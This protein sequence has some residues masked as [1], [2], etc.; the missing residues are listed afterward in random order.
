[1][2]HVQVQFL[3]RG[4]RLVCGPGEEERLQDL[5][6]DLAERLNLLD[7][8][9]GGENAGS[10]RPPEMML[11]IMT[12]LTLLD[13]NYDQRA[14]L[15]YWRQEAESRNAADPEK[16]QQMEHAMAATLQNIAGRLEK[17]ARPDTT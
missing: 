5:A 9:F 1:M 7:Q 13:E 12:A 10:P 3:G 8:R 6:E 14:E 11:W 17:L 15:D 16:R 2:N 4:Y